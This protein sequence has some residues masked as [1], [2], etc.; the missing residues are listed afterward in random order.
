MKRISYSTKIELEI[1]VTLPEG[2][3]IVDAEKH[4]HSFIQRIASQHTVYGNGP[5]M[6][7]KIRKE[8]LKKLEYSLENGEE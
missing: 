8:Q 5:G 6:S 2:T 7:V 3:N 4:I 1:L